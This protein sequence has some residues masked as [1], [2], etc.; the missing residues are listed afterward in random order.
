MTTTSFSERIAKLIAL[1]AKAMGGP[2]SALLGT[3]YLDE[4]KQWI[5]PGIAHC[6]KG[7]F[8]E[9]NAAFIVAL[10]NDFPFILAELE[11]RERKLEALV[12]ALREAE[13]QIEYLHAKFQSTGTGEATLSRI[14]SAL[15]KAKA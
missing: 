1:R 9:A 5:I 10:E 11:A 7:K 4:D 8:S 2:W 12:E 15:T 6:G 3:S 14:R 13:L